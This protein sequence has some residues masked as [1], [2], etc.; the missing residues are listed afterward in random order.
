[1]VPLMAFTALY[2]LGLTPII[3]AAVRQMGGLPQTQ[4][5]TSPQVT[6]SFSEG[7]PTL[8]AWV[9]WMSF[10][11]VLYVIVRNLWFL[12]KNDKTKKSESAHKRDLLC[13]LYLSVTL[14]LIGRISSK[15]DWLTPGYND[16][17]TWGIPFLVVVLLYFI[18]Y[19]VMFQLVPAK[20]ELTYETLCRGNNA[21]TIIILLLTV[22]LVLAVVA[23]LMETSWNVGGNGGGPWFFSFYVGTFVVVAVVHAVLFGPC[24]PGDIHV[25]HWYWPLPLAHAACFDTELSAWAQA[26]FI[27]VHL[28]GLILFGAAPVFPDKK[29][30]SSSVVLVQDSP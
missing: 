21:Y 16:R 18:L 7:P 22:V 1:M 24:T 19:T 13:M 4:T 12:H 14:T 10:Q 28:H 15:M 2:A 6:T 23:G 8:L 27:A 5:Q 29:P 17:A 26:M 11:L 20:I 3:L 30:L 9:V 25:H